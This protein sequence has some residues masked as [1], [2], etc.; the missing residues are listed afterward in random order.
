MTLSVCLSVCSLISL[1]VLHVWGS[2]FVGMPG[3]PWVWFLHYIKYPRGGGITME[4]M[5]MLD[6]D[7]VTQIIG[8]CTCV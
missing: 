5:W 8:V 1:S 2:N 7:Y 3:G 4:P 6:V